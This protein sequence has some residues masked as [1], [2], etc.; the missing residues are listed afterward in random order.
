M[1]P[2]ALEFQCTT[3]TVLHREFSQVSK[4]LKTR[5]GEVD[6]KPELKAELEIRS[7]AWRQAAARIEMSTG[8]KAEQKA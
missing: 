3:F 8:F 1:G 5:A 4:D 2:M 7:D 6:V